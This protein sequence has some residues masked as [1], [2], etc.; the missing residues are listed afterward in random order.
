[1]WSISSVEK[2][3]IK[4][5]PYHT[6]V[7]RFG[8]LKISLNTSPNPLL[9]LCTSSSVSPSREALE[10]QKVPLYCMPSGISIPYGCEDEELVAYGFVWPKVGK[11]V[12][13]R[14]NLLSLWIAEQNVSS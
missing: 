11:C 4:I 7:S 5:D 6:Y 3:S 10:I 12:L 13:S 8:S 1:M 2:T 9:T 14:V